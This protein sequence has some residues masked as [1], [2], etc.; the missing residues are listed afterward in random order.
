VHGLFALKHAEH[1]Q[2]LRIFRLPG[3]NRGRGRC[4]HQMRLQPGMQFAQDVFR[5]LHQAGSLAD[6]LVAALV[7]LHG[8]RTG[9]GEHFAILGQGELG[10]DQAAAAEGSLDYQ[11]TQGEAADNAIAVGKIYALG[12][13]PGGNSLTMSPR[14]AICFQRSVLEAGYT[15][16][17]PVPSTAMVPPTPPNAP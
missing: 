3:T 9:Q 7:G 14:A 15:R 5:A 4:R 12:P 8:G 1:E 17:R 10:C 11:Y 2:L 13:V 16:S 6:E